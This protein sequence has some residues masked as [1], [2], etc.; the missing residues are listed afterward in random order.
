MVK[1]L[2]QLKRRLKAGTVFEI[3]ECNRENYIGQRRR[4]TSSD[5]QGFYSVIPGEPEHKF[6]LANKGKGLW[7]P[8]G[9]A[10]F[11]EFRK[12][13]ESCAVFH[14][15]KGERKADSLIMRFRFVEDLEDTE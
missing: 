8:W 5:T 14:N 2:A 11:W 13:D 10:P 9:K 3:T 7:H 4:I 6:S 15:V 12:S 1:N